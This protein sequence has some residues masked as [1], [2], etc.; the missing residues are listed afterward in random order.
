M[1]LTFLFCLGVQAPSISSKSHGDELEDGDMDPS[2]MFDWGLPDQYPPQ[3]EPVDGTF[4]MF[5]ITLYDV[6]I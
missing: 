4:L 2:K 1:L 5:M 6:N 3:P